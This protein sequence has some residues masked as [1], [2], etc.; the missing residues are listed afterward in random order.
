[1]AKINDQEDEQ[2]SLNQL[3]QTYQPAATGGAAA[4]AAAGTAAAGAGLA[5]A[6]RAPDLS[7]VAAF[8]G[9]F[10]TSVLGVPVAPV[11]PALKVEV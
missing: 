9:F 5:G 7:G 10:S 6:V 8:L 11:L 1:M 4:G 3:R 2:Y